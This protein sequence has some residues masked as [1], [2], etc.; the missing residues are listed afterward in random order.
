M[1]GSRM[2]R[3]PLFR[4]KEDRFRLV[5]INNPHPMW[6]YDHQ[7]LHFLE[8]NP[9]AL[10]KYGYTRQEFLRMKITEI[11]PKEQVP[12][13]LAEHKNFGMKIKHIGEWQHRLK[14][15]R[16]IDVEITAYP[17]YFAG[18]P[19]ILVQAQD[20]TERKKAQ[21]V[22]RQLAVVEERNRIAREIHDTL[23]Q[24]FTGILVQLE[25]AQD[26]LGTG[27]RQANSHIVRARILA[28]KSLAEARRS[29]S[30]LR[31]RELE[32]G[33][34]PAA[35]KRLAVETTNGEPSIQCLIKGKPREIAPEIEY[36]LLRIS[37]EAVTNIVRHAKAKKVRIRLTFTERNIKLVIQDDGRGFSPK[38]T[39]DGF[40]LVGMRERAKQIGARLS[41]KSAHGLGT[42]VLLDVVL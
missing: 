19:A 3:T 39:L 25:A 40:G 1:S 26:V 5:L 42:R 24:A 11:R 6:I 2:D 12:R 21:D 32:R 14:N 17:F 33:G 37:Q 38:N 27:E 31:P 16:L 36:N 10:A 29:V 4:K 7:T 34:L 15:G 8:V 28:R 20:I 9:A 18:R 13:L 30:E 22:L 23:A 35:I 41:L